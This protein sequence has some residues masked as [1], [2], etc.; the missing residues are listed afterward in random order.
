M[1][2]QPRKLAKVRG[3][4]PTKKGNKWKKK[5]DNNNNPRRSGQNVRKKLNNTKSKELPGRRVNEDIKGETNTFV[6]GMYRRVEPYDYSFNCFVKGRWIGKSLI[7][8]FSKEFQANTREH[9]ERAISNG[10]ITVNNRR[11]LPDVKLKN[12]QQICNTVHRHEP[13]VCSSAIDVILEDDNYVVVN[14]PASIPV[15][16]CG[17]YRHNTVLALLGHEQHKWGLYTCHRLDRLTSGV[18]VFAKTVSAATVMEKALKARDVKK[19]YLCRVV[20]KFPKKCTCTEPIVVVSH[21]V[22]VCSVGEEGKPCETEFMRLS[23]NASTNTS[24]VECKP[25][26]GRMHQLRVH[27]RHLGHPIDNDPIY[28]CCEWDQSVEEVVEAISARRFEMDETTAC[29]PY[30]PTKMREGCVDCRKTYKD[31]TKD[32]MCIHLHAWKLSCSI[33]TFEAPRPQWSIVDNAE[34][35]DNEEDGEENQVQ[36]REAETESNNVNNTFT[37]FTCSVM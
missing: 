12:N 14:K 27:L 30:D 18:L 20:G 33:G 7:D 4:T 19:T 25:H 28:N 35:E 8:V 2:E 22:G 29:R 11:V 37:N 23:Y 10:L 26:T 3:D 6:D 13:P 17:R 31:P 15:H 9:Y 16:P 36:E 32:K 24:I 34:E 5:C 1:S 21:R